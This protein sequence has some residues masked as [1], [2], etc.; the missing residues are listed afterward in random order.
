MP[1]F[2]GNFLTERLIFM[3]PLILSLSVHE[4]AH[5][6]TAWKFGDDTAKLLGRMTLNPLAHI[7]PVGTILLPLL[8]IP[9]GWAKPVP[10]NPLRFTRKY[11]MATGLLWTAAAGP[12]SNLVLAAIS[13]TILFVLTRVAPGLVERNRELGLFFEYLILMNVLLALFN[14]LPIPPLDGSRIADSLMPRRWRPAWD[15]LCSLGPLALAAVIFLP[16]FLG[17]SLFRW[18][19]TKTLELIAWVTAK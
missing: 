1:D 12:I 18:P 17:F 9:F 4:W 14:C 10:I 16:M 2:G 19:I 6:W 11:S 13:C 3:I 5:A 7:D 8:G 15:Q